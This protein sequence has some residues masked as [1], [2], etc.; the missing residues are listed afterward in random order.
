MFLLGGAKI[1]ARKGDFHGRE[2]EGD[3]GGYHALT[4]YL[5]VNGA[6]KAI[7][8]YKKAFGATELMRM[9]GPNGKI[10]HAEVRIGDS[11]LMLADEDPSMGFRGPQ[12]GG[13]T[14]ISLL[15]YVEDCDA[16]INRAVAAGA[17]LTRPPADQFY[18][19]RSG[20]VTDPFG[21]AWYISTHVEDVP[22][23]EMKRRSDEKVREAE[24]ATASAP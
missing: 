20:G 17:K 7:D 14:A 13:G 6:A 21:H 8:F 15:L 22:P 23:D 4:P 3:S 19:D 11:A 2:S 10:G 5:I 9:P 12:S 18:G 16:V 1:N 24:K